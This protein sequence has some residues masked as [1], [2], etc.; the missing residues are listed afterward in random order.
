[1]FNSKKWT[2]DYFNEKSKQ[3]K[4][5]RHRSESLFKEIYQKDIRLREASANCAA[6]VLLNVYG[7]ALSA[8]LVKKYRQ[9]ICN[10]EN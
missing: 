8:Y 3:N 4:I 7:I 6:R 10:E 1:M 9:Q 2:T 5:N